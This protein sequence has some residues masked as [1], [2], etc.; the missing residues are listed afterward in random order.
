[1]Y[2]PL[3]H[4]VPVET[5]I[6]RASF[7]SVPAKQFQGGDAINITNNALSDLLAEPKQCSLFWLFASLKKNKCFFF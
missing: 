2:S 5:L 1:M 4:F 3:M 6:T 7:T